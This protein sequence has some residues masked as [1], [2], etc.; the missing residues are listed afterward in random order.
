MKKNKARK[1]RPVRKEEC[2]HEQCLTVK[3]VEC[4]KPH[5][6]STL[7]DDMFADLKEA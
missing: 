1:S 7:I 5:V 6:P 4:G 2:V 3:C